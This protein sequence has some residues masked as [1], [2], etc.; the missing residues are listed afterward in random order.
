MIDIPSG[1]Q[2]P[3]IASGLQACDLVEPRL[4]ARPTRRRRS[5]R[6]AFG[7]PKRLT[8]CLIKLRTTSSRNRNRAVGEQLGQR[9]MAVF[10]Y[11]GPAPFAHALLGVAERFGNLAHAELIDHLDADGGVFGGRRITIHG[12]WRPIRGR[13]AIVILIDRGSRLFPVGK[14]QERW[15]GRRVQQRGSPANVIDSVCT[16]PEHPCRDAPARTR[17]SPSVRAWV[18]WPGR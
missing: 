9:P 11:A 14:P 4:V 8:G 12:L 1:D 16:L 18:T 17:K 13:I 5:S 10:R 7:R 6:F 2:H 15:R 3:N